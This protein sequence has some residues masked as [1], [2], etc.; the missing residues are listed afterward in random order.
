MSD[1]KPDYERLGQA[2]RGRR[3][4]VPEGGEALRALVRAGV[5]ASAVADGRQEACVV[6]VPY[7]CGRQE[8]EAALLG[9]REHGVEEVFL[10]MRND[11][12][13]VRRLVSGSHR[14]WWEATAVGLGFTRHPDCIDYLGYVEAERDPPG[15]IVLPLRLPP[16]RVRLAHPLADLLRERDLHMDMLRETGRRSDAHLVRY[17]A[18]ARLVRSGDVVLDA[19]CGMG[20]GS[21]M[22]ARAAGT[23]GRVTGLDLSEASVAYAKGMFA[24]D[25]LEFRVQDVTDLSGVPAG[26]VDLITSFETLEHVRDPRGLL[27]EFHRV[28]RPGGR[29]VVSVP[30]DWRDHTGKDPNPWH[31]QVYDWD[32]L[33]A[34]MGERF[35]VEIGLGQTAGGGRALP[36]RTVHMGP[37]DWF[38]FGAG[39]RPPR[40]SEWWLAVC[41]RDPLD[42]DP[43][44]RSAPGG[45]PGSLLDFRSSYDHPA[46]VDA[47]VSFN[48]RILDGDAR[49]SFAERALD[50][51][52]PG[53]CDEAALLCVL[54]Y[55]AIARGDDGRM[56]DLRAR[57]AS[58]LSG[59][60]ACNPHALRWRLSLGFAA[61]LAARELG[62]LEGALSG[63]KAVASAD[64][65]S[66]GPTLA[67]KAVAAAH[68]AALVSLALGRREEALSHCAIGL[69]AWAR[70]KEAPLADYVGRVEDPFWFPV[71]ETI[72]TDVGAAACVD[73]A[74]SIRHGDRA[75][76][77]RVQNLYAQTG[78]TL[79]DSLWFGSRSERSRR[80][81]LQ[82]NRARAAWTSLKTRVRRP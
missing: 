80:V 29:I 22:L 2:L 37:R 57:S 12:P 15:E 45:S 75:V 52:A 39:E 1:K 60:D 20:Y 51:V 25:G 76:S 30:N 3:V 53:S 44:P 32:R 50:R 19:A 8:K 58:W 5:Q 23:E 62:D 68:E 79:R 7:D 49:R 31:F 65:L 9:I 81:L 43:T 61:A 26:S 74:R 56:R 70:A 21:Y 16:E 59:S 47:V 55:D 14:E 78:W 35:I 40:D 73:L 10:L 69:G 4:L 41:M 63:F 17:A 46:L 64:F 18:A 71:F 33:A 72:E 48:R 42:P 11:R 38:L 77:L 28:L 54:S 36:R 67:T 13:R 27:A 24:R 34:E 66:F 82:A 6:R